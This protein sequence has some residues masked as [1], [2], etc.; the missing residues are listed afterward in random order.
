MRSDVGDI[1]FK[2]GGV[3]PV[4]PGRVS[5]YDSLYAALDKV[6]LNVWARTTLPDKGIARRTLLATRKY[7]K[8]RKIKVVSVIEEKE[9]GRVVLWIKK[10]DEMA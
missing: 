3:P 5:K 7:L 1:K 10:L 9:D 2:I 6:E 4:K 8:P